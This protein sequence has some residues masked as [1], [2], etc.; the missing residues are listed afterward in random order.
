MHISSI[1]LQHERF[2]SLDCY[3]F[4]LEIFQKTEEIEFTCPVTFFIGENGTGKSTLLR[5]IARRCNIHIWEEHE[6]RRD[7]SNPYEDLL[8]KSLEVCWTNGEVTGSFFAS[9]IFRH[10]TEVLDIW[11]A[12]DPEC[13]KYF[14]NGP[15]V[16]KSHGQSHMT[17]FDTRFRRRGLYLLDEPENALS[18]KMQLALLRLLAGLVRR[19]D[20]QFI[21]VTHSPIILAFPQSKIYRFDTSPI[22]RISYEDTDYYQVYR[23]FLNNRAEYLENL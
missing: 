7:Q 6:G 9:E 15:F 22:Q 3:P 14:G 23:D 2:P 18:P 17:F 21:I 19:G 13:V 1:C 11:G 10:F 4:N 16:M 12:A 20:V 5:A 8:H